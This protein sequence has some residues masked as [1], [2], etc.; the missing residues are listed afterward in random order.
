MNI[1]RFSKPILVICILGCS[2]FA[3]AQQTTYPIPSCQ[4]YFS[5]RG[6]ATSAIVE[7]IDNAK[8]NVLVQAYS[9]TS[10]PIAETLV[11]AFERGIKVQVLLDKSQRAQ[12]H[13]AARFLVQA[14]IPVLI[15]ASH[16]IAHNKVIVIDNS[17][18]V[19]GSFNF[20]KAAEDRNAENLLVLRS[21]ELADRYADNW[22]I[23]QRHSTPF[24]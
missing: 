24:H 10:E 5:P 4:A 8:S 13:T 9:F 18:V 16:A 11:R 21:K 6:G 14:G 12:T 1:S 3:N 22:R 7:T 19:T 23:H 17:I 2:F 15:D 20:T